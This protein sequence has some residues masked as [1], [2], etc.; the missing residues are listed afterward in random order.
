MMKSIQ[1][2][3]IGLGSVGRELARQVIGQREAITRRYGFTIDYLAIADSTGI[4][5]SG[6]PMPPAMVLATI[7]AKEAGRTLAEQGAPRREGLGV[8]PISAQGIAVDVSA[9]AGTTVFLTDAVRFG[10]RVV[11]AN[12]QPLCTAYHDFLTLTERGATRYEATVGAGL[13]VI[14]TL[15]GLLDSGDEMLRIEAAMSGT[16]GFLSAELEA[17]KLLSTAVREAHALGYTEPDPRDD[18]SGMDVARKALILARTCGLPW[19]LSEIAVEPWFPPEFAQVSRDAFMDRL[20]ELNAPFSERIAAARAA[21]GVLRYVAE[22]SPA[23]AS[24]GFKILP[25]DHPLASLRGPDN[26]FSLTTTRY[27]ERPLVIR[28]PGAG[29]AVTAA[30]VL[31]DIVATAR[32]MRG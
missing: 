28:G 3:Q 20:D 6:T 32:E 8:L 7:A 24:V 26:L 4:I 21:G 9:Y 13:P 25:A 1:I 5:F 23:G 2:A 10:H 15:Q 27:N 29:L 16:L 11:L 18:L 12:K 17:G 19:E 14:G 30:G 22:I 31:S